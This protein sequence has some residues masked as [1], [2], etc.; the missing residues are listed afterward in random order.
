MVVTDVNKLGEALYVVN[1]YAKKIRDERRRLKWYLVEH[2]WGEFWN[3]EPTEDLK[4]LFDDIDIY[5][6]LPQI[7]KCYHPNRFDSLSEMK[8]FSNPLKN[9]WVGFVDDD[10]FEEFLI[11]E[12]DI[13]GFHAEFEW[14]IARWIDCETPFNIWGVTYFTP[15]QLKKIQTE[16]FDFVQDIET[17]R[18]VRQSQKKFLVDVEQREGDLYQK[19]NFLGEVQRQY[20]DLKKRLIE[21]LNLKPFAI[22]RFEGD[23]EHVYPM[24]VIGNYTFHTLF[25]NPEE[26]RNPKL[27]QMAETKAETI[28]SDL[29]IGQAIKIVEDCLFSLRTNTSEDLDDLLASVLAG[30][31]DVFG[32]EE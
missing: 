11:F 24:Y 8:D 23:E 13:V 14:F 7:P 6:F 32:K 21:A 5:N 17:A 19:L 10:K 28:K 25:Y 29:T 3:Y 18:N 15:A 31:D 2:P 30:L 20:Y 1:Q 12:T 26:A 4:Y 22:H 16:F 27:Q 9:K